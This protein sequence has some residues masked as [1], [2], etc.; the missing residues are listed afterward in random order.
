MAIFTAGGDIVGLG[1]D[2][3]SK[4]PEEGWEMIIK[5]QDMDKDKLEAVL[6]PVVRRIEDVRKM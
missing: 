1:F 2:D 3:L 4:A 6:K 5:V